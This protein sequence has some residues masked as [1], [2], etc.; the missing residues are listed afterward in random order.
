M[1][2]LVGLKLEHFAR[3]NLVGP[4]KVLFC[5]DLLLVTNYNRDTNVHTIMSFLLT[6]AR[7]IRH[8]KLLGA[9]AG[10][11]V[12]SWCL[13]GDRLVVRDNKSKDLLL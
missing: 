2:R 12:E 9:N 3:T 7:L 11:Y 5:S 4:G 13:A 1:H 8:R 6:A 10:V